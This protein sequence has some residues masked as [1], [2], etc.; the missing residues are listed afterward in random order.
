VPALSAER[1]EVVAVID[2]R[3]GS[4]LKLCVF[5]G[6]AAYRG[7]PS[8]D[9]RPGITVY[10]RTRVR[11]VE[12]LQELSLV[13]VA[14]ERKMP[15]METISCPHCWVQ[16]TFARDELYVPAKSTLKRCPAP[17]CGRQ[18]LLVMT[19]DGSV[20]AEKR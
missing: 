7:R 19:D 20:R 17:G 11:R 13:R 1:P 4:G 14:F 8:R 16:I 15:A 3:Q 5:H 10:A 12:F 9:Q 6:A 2:V 18:V